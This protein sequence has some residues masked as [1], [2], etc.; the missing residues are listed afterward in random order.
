MEAS[1]VAF[2]VCG[3]AGVLMM[4]KAAQRGL[5]VPPPWQRTG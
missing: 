3:T 5:I 2:L 1:L 4:A